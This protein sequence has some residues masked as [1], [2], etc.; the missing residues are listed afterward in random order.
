MHELQL[1]GADQRGRG[2]QAQVGLEPVGQDVG[3]LR[4]PA[5]G[6]GL[7]HERQQP[8]T[9]LLVGDPVEGEQVGHVPVLEADPAVLQAADL[10]PGCADLIA[11]LFRR[12]PGVL[13]Q[14]AQLGAEQHAQYGRAAPGIGGQGVAV[15]RA[16]AHRAEAAVLTGR[17]AARVD[18]AQSWLRRGGSALVWVPASSRGVSDPALPGRYPDGGKGSSRRVH[19]HNT[20]DPA[21]HGRPFRGGARAVSGRA[22]GHRRRTVTELAKAGC[23]TL[24]PSR[25]AGNRPVLSAGR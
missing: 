5:L 18:R 10:G 17:R 20:P 25:R 6:V 14:A 11:G 16:A 3:V 7:L 15:R 23:R 9:G 1:E 4:P 8:G 13:A 12:D 21:G 19:R 2:L 22:P 24:R